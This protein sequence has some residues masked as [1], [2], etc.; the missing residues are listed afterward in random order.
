MQ[1]PALRTCE[2]DLRDGVLRVVIDHPP[3]N[4]IDVVMAKDLY[5]LVTLDRVRARDPRGRRVQPR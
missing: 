5:R 4:L 2:V 3:I 1:R